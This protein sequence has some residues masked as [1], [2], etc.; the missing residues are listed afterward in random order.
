MRRALFLLAF[1]AVAPAA[2]HRNLDAD[3]AVTV[4]DAYPVKFREPSFHGGWHGDGA[5]IELEY[6]LARNWQLNLGERPGLLFNFN[7]ETL[8]IPAFA[9]K[10]EGDV[11]TGDVSWKGIV[12]R[13]FGRNR[14]HLNAG[15]GRE[16]RWETVAGWDRPIAQQTILVADIVARDREPG[17]IEIGVRHQ[18]TPRQ[19]WSAGV[20]VERDR[21]YF[22]LALTRAF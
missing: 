12:T 20:G 13:S 19:V 4:E 17:A 1:V 21:V 18:V 5:L 16:H 8:R 9:L 7:T 22:R 14:I 3:L 2:D 6:G 10:V 15:T 11:S